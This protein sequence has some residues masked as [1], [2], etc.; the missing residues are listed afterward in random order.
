MQ[1]A[2]ILPNGTYATHGNNQDKG[3]RQFCGCIN[4][5]DIG[6]YNTC[7]HLCEYCYANASKEMALKNWEC[8]K[9]ILQEKPLLENNILSYELYKRYPKHS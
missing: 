5:K 6:E 8:H 2:I 3:Q 9:I 7:P 1:D 4:S